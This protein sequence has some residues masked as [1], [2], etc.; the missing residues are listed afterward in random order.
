MNYCHIE[1]GA[2]PELGTPLGGFSC[3]DCTFLTP[4]KKKWQ[5]HISQ[6]GH[7][8]S[9]GAA[10][11]TV[12]LQTFSRGRH[13]R[14]WVVKD[15][16]D[17][18]RKGESD[19]IVGDRNTGF[20]QMLL[21]YQKKHDKRWI[22]R[23]RIADDPS[24]VENQ[25]RWVQYMRWAALFDRKDKR[26]IYLASLMAR[27]VGIRTATQRRSDESVGEVDP[28][29]IRLGG[30]FDRVMRQCTARLSLV[31]HETLLW[32]NSIDPMKPAG[33]PFAL[34]Q[35]G[36]SMGRYRQFMRRCLTYCVR[37]ARL[38]RE[39]AQQL[40]GIRWTD[41]QWTALQQIVVVLD[42]LGPV[43]PEDVSEEEEDTSEEEEQ[44]QELDK[45][46]FAYCI[47]ML[48]QRVLV[49]WYENPLL[50]FAAVLGINDARGSYREPKHYTGSLAGLVWCSRMLMLEEAF[51]DSPEDPN[52]MTMETVEA[53]Q[54]VQRRWLAGGSYSPMSTFITWMAYGK[55]FRTKEGGTPKVLWESN[56][57][58]MRYLGQSIR[59]ADFITTADAAIVEA[60]AVLDQL[61]FEPW[62]TI[63]ATIEMRRIHD[64]V[65]FEGTGSSF[66]TDPRNRWLQPGFRFVVERAR[67][68][69]WRSDQRPDLKEVKA[70]IGRL[71]TFKRLLMVAKHIW[72]GQPGRG[73]EMT[74][75]K[76]CDTAQMMRN[77]FVFD[78]EV[79]LITD[80][81]KNRS[82]RGL[83]RKVAR[84]LPARIG[85]MVIAYIAW[86]MPFEEFIHDASGVAGPDSTLWSYMWKDARRGPWETEQLSDGLATLTGAHLGVEL[87]VSDYRHAAIGFAR[88]IKGIV[89]R[90]A[91]MEV[92]EGGGEDGRRGRGGDDV[93]A[94][95]GVDLGRAVDTR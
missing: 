75:L 53:F 59:V 95:V 19:S 24:G 56:G 7:N 5:S 87:M 54:E 68:R 33:Q 13:A 38:G 61:F 9:G 28:V 66:A 49:N 34:K 2:I 52:E 74:T 79:L 16:R 73:P 51:R 17:Q 64:S 32:L 83:G 76:H 91:E 40:H 60:E 18:D 46:V 71:K 21:D 10:Q 86:L 26:I 35:N 82:I 90:R 15:K 92:G 36:K 85:R 41:A 50:F 67:T 55:G 11:H 89:V 81:D 63:A 44:E 48:Q 42:Q 8:R 65:M 6:T 14:Y 20:Q 23:R 12:Q 70:W 47:A 80:R 30:S 84:F 88:V 58:V 69:M 27:P 43:L 78:G 94:A 4:N 57:Q 1:V 62:E 29:L 77:V 22:E 93:G 3:F 45:A 37:M 72:G 25:S 39:V 31:P